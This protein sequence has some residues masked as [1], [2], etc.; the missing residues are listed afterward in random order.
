[1]DMLMHLEQLSEDFKDMEIIH[2]AKTQR[3]LD[4]GSFH[5]GMAALVQLIAIK[6]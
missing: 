3:D 4:E 6:K 5:Q 1:M 2:L